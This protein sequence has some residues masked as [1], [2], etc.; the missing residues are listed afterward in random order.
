M[1]FKLRLVVGIR[2]EPPESFCYSPDP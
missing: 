2:P 1:L